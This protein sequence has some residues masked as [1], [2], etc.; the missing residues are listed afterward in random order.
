VLVD[1]LSRPPRQATSADLRRVGFAV[2][3]WGGLA[4]VDH[5]AKQ[6]RFNSGHPALQG[7][8]L[9]ALTQRTR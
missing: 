6:L 9:G 5:L 8:L 7:A 3:V 4:E 1:E 2:G